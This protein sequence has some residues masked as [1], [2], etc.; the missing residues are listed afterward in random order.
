VTKGSAALL[1]GVLGALSGV[2][3]GPASAHVTVRPALATHG[4]TLLLHFHVPNERVTADTVKLIVQFPHD[5]TIA[6]VRPQPVGGWIARV[7]TRRLA[8][9]LPAPGGAVLDVVDT[10]TWS[11]GAIPPHGS[12]DFPVRAGP[13]P[14]N[15]DVLVFK[16]LQFYSNGEVVRWIEESRPGEPRP[17]NPAPILRLVVPSTATAKR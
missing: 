13:L 3:S 8:T 9:P 15:G 17:P 14:P 5:R 16:A 6:S 4:A 2:L 10:I 12:L 1:A 11:G 7:T